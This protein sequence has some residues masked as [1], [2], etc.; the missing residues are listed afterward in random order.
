MSL[1]TRGMRKE[2]IR[3]CVQQLWLSLEQ[4]MAHVSAAEHNSRLHVPSTPTHAFFMHEITLGVTL[5]DLAKKLEHMWYHGM[6]YNLVLMQTPKKMSKLDVHM[7]HW[8]LGDLNIINTSKLY[9][10]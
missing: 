10:Y 5:L 3:G 6:L 2:N 9:N 1:L 4:I 8:F 7:L